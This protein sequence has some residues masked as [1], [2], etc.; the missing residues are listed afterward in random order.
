MPPLLLESLLF[1]F[2]ALFFVSRRSWLASVG[3]LWRARASRGFL[4]SLLVHTLHARLAALSCLYVSAVNGP[5]DL[6]ISSFPLTKGVFSQLFSNTRGF[7]DPLCFGSK[8]SFICAG[9]AT[10]KKLKVDGSPFEWFF[11]EKRAFL[12][13]RFLPPLHLPCL[14][15][16]LR[17]FSCLFHDS[18]ARIFHE[19]SLPPPP[20]S[21]PLITVPFLFHFFD[22]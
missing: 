13:L 1:V 21:P 3:E 15:L 8:S 17:L 14:V 22:S 5:L 19:N 10:T 16:F 2:F 20:P 11:G 18:V 6:S 9:A 12:I 7:A 4:V